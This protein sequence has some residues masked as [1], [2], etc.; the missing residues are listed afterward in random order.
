MTILEILDRDELKSLT[1]RSDLH[2]VRMVLVNYGLIGLGFALPAV[3]DHWI[4]WG[5]G[6][7]ILGGRALGLGIL[8]HE[9]AHQTLF[10]SRRVNGWMGKWV[11]GGLPNV[12]YDAYRQGHLAHHRLA[13]TE[14]DP[15]LAFVDTYPATGTSLMRKGLRD[16][17]GWNGLKHLVY[18]I[19][20]FSLPNQWPFLLNHGVLI[21][22]L[23]A[24]GVPE[25]YGCWWLGQLFVFPLVV[26]LRVMGEHGAVSDPLHPDP[27]ANTGTTLAGPLAR[28]LWA[29]NY[30]NFHVEHHFAAAVPSYRL[31]AMH[32][33][34]QSKGAYDGW[35]CVLP[36]YRAVIQRCWNPAGTAQVE[37]KKRVVKGTL[38]NMQ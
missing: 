14:Q 33:L 18:Q 8:V 30:V 25:V 24:A 34:L 20:T 3:W 15:D 1:R 31:P 12:P 26:R 6:A 35:H 38:N 2:A 32:R 22:L 13:G 17:S 4:A 7:L 9:T 10:Q 36:S 27:R 28:L 23:W 37:G 19:S 29:P 21:A 16:V 5:L 11:F